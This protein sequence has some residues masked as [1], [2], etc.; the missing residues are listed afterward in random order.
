VDPEAL[1]A[2]AHANGVDFVGPPLAVSDP[3]SAET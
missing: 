1:F 2:I 3:M